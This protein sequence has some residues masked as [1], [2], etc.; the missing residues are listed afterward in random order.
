MEAIWK[1]LIRRAANGLLKMGR[2]AAA[3]TE[4]DLDDLGVEH[5]AKALAEAGWIK[6]EDTPDREPAPEP[7]GGD[8]GGPP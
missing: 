2:A 6:A 3:S 5:V 4:T 7:T 8:G 1:E